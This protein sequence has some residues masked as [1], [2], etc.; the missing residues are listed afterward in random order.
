MKIKNKS[1]YYYLGLLIIFL[2]NNCLAEDVGTAFSYQGELLDNSSPAN[3]EYD[4]M[5]KAYFFEEDGEAD[6]VTPA[7]LNV[8]VSNGR[9]T[10]PEVDFGTDLFYQKAV[11]LEVNVRKSSEGGDYTALSPRQRLSVA[12]FAV[13]SA[14]STQ[15]E[16]ASNA[17]NST[18]AN[19][20]T[21]ANSLAAGSANMGDVLQ[22]D[23][24]AWNPAAVANNISTP[25]SSSNGDIYFNSGDVGVGLSNPVTRLHV[26]SN[27]GFELSRFDGGNQMYKSYY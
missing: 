17:T 7:F 10:I 6:P 14:F 8:T 1:K 2:V 15:A 21:V 25:W 18:T 26:D 16:F 11:F 5:F 20:A 22:F 12:P 27:N 23:G 13:Q 9:F 4:I 19:T 3:N 24:Q